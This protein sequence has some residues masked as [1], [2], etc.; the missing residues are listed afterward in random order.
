MLSFRAMLFYVIQA[1]ALGNLPLCIRG[2]QR[3]TFTVTGAH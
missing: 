1:Q 2:T 3:L